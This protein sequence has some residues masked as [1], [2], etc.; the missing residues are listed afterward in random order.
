M[1]KSNF[2]YLFVLLAGM[3]CLDACKKK[4]DPAPSKKELLVGTSSKKWKVTSATD[5][6]G[7]NA[8]PEAFPRECDRDNLLVFYTDN[9]L[10]IEEGA[11]Q[12]NPPT[13]AQGSWRLSTDEKA[14]TINVPG[15]VLNGD[16]TIIEMTNTT[17]KGTFP[18]NYQGTPV[19]INATLT[20]Q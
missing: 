9:K 13:V 17:L 2:I 16:F 7:R 10:V 15:S 4:E 3:V 6:L 19:T 11:V 8:I 5:P 14:L 18:Y 20:A 12:C 1:K